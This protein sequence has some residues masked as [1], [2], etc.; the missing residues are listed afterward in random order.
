MRAK[1]A[2]AGP[3]SAILKLLSG[4][5]GLI[6]PVE[7]PDLLL[8][9]DLLILCEWGGLILLGPFV[10]AGKNWARHL[11]IIVPIVAVFVQGVLGTAMGFSTAAIP[12]VGLSVIVHLTA[13]IGLNVKK[14]RQYF[15]GDEL[16]PRAS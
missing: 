12:S 9:S 1:C 8:W 16:P 14:S 13:L 3:V 4:T 5:L 11:F 7:H 6:P 15:E 2:R 10:L